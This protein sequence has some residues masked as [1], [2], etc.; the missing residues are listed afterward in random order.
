MYFESAQYINLLYLLY[1]QT[2]YL[3]Y[4]REIFI[5]GSFGRSTCRL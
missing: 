3:Y 4:E 2:K 1:Y 5:N